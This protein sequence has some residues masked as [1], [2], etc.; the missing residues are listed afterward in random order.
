M[1][2]RLGVAMEAM[3]LVQVT[4]QLNMGTVTYDVEHTAVTDGVGYPTQF[5][6]KVNGGEREPSLTVEAEMI[7]GR[8]A[9]TKVDLQAPPGRKVSPKHLEAVT[10]IDTLIES[11]FKAVSERV[12]PLPDGYGEGFWTAEDRE[13]TVENR[14]TLTALQ[15][16]SERGRKAL[17]DDHFKRVAAFYETHDRSVRAVADHWGKSRE[18][19]ARWVRKARE[20]GYISEED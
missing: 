3:G 9:A 14:R 4:V 19:A 7:D 13:L 11:V 2:I 18:S 1:T 17:P 10:Q 15:P 20:L 6:F 16:T 12:E 8:I 5:V